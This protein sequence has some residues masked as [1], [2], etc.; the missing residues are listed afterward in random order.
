MLQCDGVGARDGEGGCSE[1]L[2]N[3]AGVA[4]EVD[5]GG[6]EGDAEGRVGWVGVAGEGG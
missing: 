2:G 1:D 4:D 3:G 5:G 6:E